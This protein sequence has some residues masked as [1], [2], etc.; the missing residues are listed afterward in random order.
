M[1]LSINRPDVVADYPDAA[2]SNPVGFRATVE[3]GR[4]PPDFSL[5]VTALLD[6]G[7]NAAVGAIVARRYSEDG[8]SIDSGRA[9]DTPS[10]RPD[11]HELL[12]DMGGANGAASPNADVAADVVDHEWIIGE[13]ELEGKTVLHVGSGRGATSR[14]A[15]I[16]GAE[17]VDGFEPDGQLVSVARLLNA[18]HGT[19]RVSFF[20]RDLTDPSTYAEPYDVVLALSVAD[21]PEGIVETLLGITG[22]L[23]AELPSED[24]NA[25]RLLSLLDASSS[26]AEVTTMQSPER[27]YVLV[28]TTRPS[29]GA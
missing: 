14:K 24:E 5:Q 29:R 28:T 15:R 3:V 23:L 16:A 13:L 19:T 17:L 2:G 4:L 6:D 10:L 25:A 8:T 11:L 18:Y 21:L 20:E 1:P 12:S 9:M 26:A 22:L 27:R 7:S